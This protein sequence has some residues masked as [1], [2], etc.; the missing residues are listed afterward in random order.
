MVSIAQST[1][2]HRSE[3]RHRVGELDVDRPFSEWLVVAISDVDGGT[4]HPHPV[5][6]LAAESFG[7]MVVVVNTI[8]IPRESFLLGHCPLE[9]DDNRVRHRLGVETGAPEPYSNLIQ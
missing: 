8:P 5:E 2:G 6:Q 3:D 4:S 9:C 1:V 7:H